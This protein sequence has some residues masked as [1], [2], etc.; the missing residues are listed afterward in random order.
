MFVSPQSKMTPLSVVVHSPRHSALVRR[1]NVLAV[2]TLLAVAAGCRP[3]KTTKEISLY[4]LETATPQ[5]V[6]HTQRFVVADPALLQPIYQP[7][8]RR[9]GLI[10][11]ANAEAWRIY[12][13]AVPSA[14]TCP[15]LSRGMLVGLVSPAGT[16]LDGQWP[17][18]WDV[19]RL[20]GGAGLIQAEFVGG[21]YL[22]DGVTYV[23]TAFVPQ[24]ESVLVVTV[25]GINYY[26]E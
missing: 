5:Q 18:A 16:S 22:A 2:L 25:D 19:V 17:L 24:L 4:D 14:G 13:L 9:L 26:P 6:S 8:G 1:G 23:E 15:D 21:N 3:I 7:L 12:K 11:V 10:Q 20:H